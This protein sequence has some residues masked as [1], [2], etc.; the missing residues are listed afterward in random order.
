MPP[1]ALPKV[2]RMGSEATD[3]AKPLSGGSAKLRRAATMLRQIAE[4]LETEHEEPL[5]AESAGPRDTRALAS[6]ARKI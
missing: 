5:G 4:H 1:C 6:L 3:E 2:D